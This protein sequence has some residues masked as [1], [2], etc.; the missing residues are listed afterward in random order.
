MQMSSKWRDP[1][2]AQEELIA[3]IEDRGKR[4]Q[5]KIRRIYKVMQTNPAKARKLL[6]DED[7]PSYKRQQ[8]ETMISQYGWRF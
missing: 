1:T 4:G 8:V 2:A 5:A 7:I 3:S 6:E